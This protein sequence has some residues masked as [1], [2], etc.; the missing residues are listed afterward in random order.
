MPFIITCKT[1]ISAGHQLFLPY[2]SKCNNPH[3]HNYKIEI[4]LK[5]DNLN[6]HGM[7]FDFAV[8][9]TA[10]RDKY[11]HQ[12]LNEIF[13]P[14]T[15]ENFAKQIND[16]VVALLEKSDCANYVEVVGVTVFETK[17]TSSCYT[18]FL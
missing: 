15:S 13:T 4:A 6:A 17:T 7:V 16:D 10:L 2:P 9:K 14:T 8:L 1:E 5:A 12:N 3:G 11:D 18:S